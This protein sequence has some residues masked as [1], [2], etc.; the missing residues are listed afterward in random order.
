MR[1]RVGNIV[2]TGLAVD[3]S[4]RLESDLRELFR[5]KAGKVRA[6][7]GYIALW[8]AWGNLNG[9]KSCRRLVSRLVCEAFHGPA[10]AHKPLAMHGNDDSTDNRPENL[11]WGSH[12][13]NLSQEGSRARARAAWVRRKARMSEEK[14][15]KAA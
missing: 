9:E 6:K 3:D 7:P 10:P 1:R 4:L 8:V 12:K 11:S 5:I 13:D 2:R 14:A 15:R